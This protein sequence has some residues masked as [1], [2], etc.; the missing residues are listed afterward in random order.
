MAS[1]MEHRATIP[2]QREEWG[3]VR[4][5]LSVSSLCSAKL[6]QTYNNPEYDECKL[7]METQERIKQALS[8][9]NEIM[10]EK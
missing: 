6:A 4:E 3:M 2:T 5:A 9:I 1:S 8:T 10:G 7:A